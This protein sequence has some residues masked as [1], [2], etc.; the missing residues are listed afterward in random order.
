MVEYR[1]SVLLRTNAAPAD[2]ALR[3]GH[4][5]GAPLRPHDRRLPVAILPGGFPEI[6]GGVRGNGPQRAAAHANA[7]P[8]C[9]RAAL[10]VAAI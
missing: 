7:L 4:R 5:T 2:I 3:R 6:R 1:S 8:H 9:A 10:R